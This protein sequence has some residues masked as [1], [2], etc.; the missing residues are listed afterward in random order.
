MGSETRHH[1]GVE[2]ERNVMRTI[3]LLDAISR[4]PSRTTTSSSLILGRP[5]DVPA[6]KVIQFF[7]FQST[8]SG[9]RHLIPGPITPGPEAMIRTAR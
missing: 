3:E 8:D 5:C 2:E 6:E 1:A 7:T 4:A 9:P